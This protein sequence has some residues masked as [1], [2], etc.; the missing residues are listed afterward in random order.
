MKKSICIVAFS[1]FFVGFLANINATQ[2]EK[3]RQQFSFDGKADAKALVEEAELST[4]FYINQVEDYFRFFQN[5]L[6][7]SECNFELEDFKATILSSSLLKLVSSNPTAIKNLVLTFGPHSRVLNL[8]SELSETVAFYKG[9]TDLCI[10]PDGEPI[11]R[12]VSLNT[13]FIYSNEI[14]DVRNA[15][16][17]SYK[18]SCNT[19]WMAGEFCFDGMSYPVLCFT[20]LQNF[21]AD[22]Q[23][24]KMYQHGE[25]NKVYQEKVADFNPKDYKYRYVIVFQDAKGRV[26]SSSYSE[27]K[28]FIKVVQGEPNGRLAEVFMALEYKK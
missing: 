11:N 1:F 27:D 5:A 10:G 15:V 3:F 23:Y 19:P 25:V 21:L 13:V 26:N 16:A 14:S 17:L 22:S 7:S 12:N 2:P 6:E 28:R 8:P 9:R 20:E 24:F 18:L 4:S